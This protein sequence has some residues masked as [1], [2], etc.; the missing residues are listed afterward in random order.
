MKE[1]V[2]VVVRDFGNI[3]DKVPHQRLPMKLKSRY[4]WQGKD[5]RGG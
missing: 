2:D 3:F 5:S 4:W 1:R